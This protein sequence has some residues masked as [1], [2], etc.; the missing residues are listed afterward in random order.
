[1]HKSNVYFKA[2]QLWKWLSCPIDWQQLLVHR[3]IQLIL[4]FT[5]QWVLYSSYV[6]RPKTNIASLAIWNQMSSM[7]PIHWG[8][9]KSLWFRI[10]LYLIVTLYQRTQAIPGFDRI[11]AKS[12]LRHIC[13]LKFCLDFLWRL[14][15]FI[16]LVGSPSCIFHVIAQDKI[17]T[18]PLNTWRCRSSIPSLRGWDSNQ[19]MWIICVVAP[20]KH[21]VRQQYSLMFHA[22]TL[23][24]HV[25]L[26]SILG[27]HNVCPVNC[28]SAQKMSHALWS[29]HIFCLSVL[30]TCFHLNT[31]MFNHF[32]HVQA[33]RLQW[34]N[35]DCTSSLCTN[36]PKPFIFLIWV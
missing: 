9:I 30:D 17:T 35:F 7:W 19:R 22:W 5:H 4:Y 24:L 10:Y 2:I 32:N 14:M 1:M 8:P 6:L 26:L 23:L 36:A 15:N 28:I 33:Q 31:T 16:H 12:V 3:P 21:Y 34:Y 13:C 25:M 11:D 29:Q 27:V 18:N 20:L